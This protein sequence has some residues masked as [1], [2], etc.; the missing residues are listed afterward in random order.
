M[1]FPVFGYRHWHQND[2]SLAIFPAHVYT[3]REISPEHLVI[4]QVLETQTV[5]GTPCI[6]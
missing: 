5:T 4:L 6:A 1:Q 3:K 2:I